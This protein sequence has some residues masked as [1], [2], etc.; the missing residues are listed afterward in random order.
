MDVSAFRKNLAVEIIEKELLVITFEMFMIKRVP[1][2]K[3][4]LRKKERQT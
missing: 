1:M 2:Q 4:I 3:N